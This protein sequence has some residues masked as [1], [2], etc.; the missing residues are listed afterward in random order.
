MRFRGKEVLY[1]KGRAAVES[2]CCGT[3]GCGFIKVPGYVLSW[4][5]GRDACGRPVSQ[6]ERI[7]EAD[8][9]REIE[10]ILRRAHPAFSQVEFL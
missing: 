10:E 5:E 9:R 6:V 8:Q 2:S 7:E 3:G 1:L 4:K